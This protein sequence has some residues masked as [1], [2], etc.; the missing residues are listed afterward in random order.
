M[1]IPTDQLLDLPQNEWV[2]N[3]QLFVDLLVA[4]FWAIVNVDEDLKRERGTPTLKHH[5]TDK[6]NFR[7]VYMNHPNLDGQMPLFPLDFPF[8]PLGQL[9]RLSL[10]KQ[11][12]RYKALGAPA[13]RSNGLFQTLWWGLVVSFLLLCLTDYNLLN[14]TQSCSYFFGWLWLKWLNH[15]PVLLVQALLS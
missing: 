7:D 9:P 4:H 12:E 3:D 1:S 2:L 8:N 6:E 14:L 5:R 11:G 13:R 10:K 15:Q